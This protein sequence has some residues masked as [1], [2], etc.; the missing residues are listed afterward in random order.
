MAYQLAYQIIAKV[1]LLFL[2]VLPCIPKS[3]PKFIVEAYESY[4]AKSEEGVP[5]KILFEAEKKRG[6]FKILLQR[7]AIIW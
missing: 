6:E 3:L 1:D 5:E 4:L 7:L 2:Y